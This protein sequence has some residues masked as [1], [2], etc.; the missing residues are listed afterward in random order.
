M[1]QQ[2]RGVAQLNEST[3]RLISNYG[4]GLYADRIRAVVREAIEEV[5]L[6]YKG[7]DKDTAIIAKGKTALR[8]LLTRW[9]K[10]E[11]AGSKLGKLQ[12]YKI[13]DAKLINGNEWLFYPEKNVNS[14]HVSW[15]VGQQE[16]HVKFDGQQPVTI[17]YN[18]AL[19]FARIGQHGG[20]PTPTQQ[21]QAKTIIGDWQDSMLIQYSQRQAIAEFLS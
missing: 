15:V 16:I 5:E 6:S 1:A 21:Q 9:Q 8:D 14:P 3:E 17:Y 19:Q 10:E 11:I 7:S 12:L 4:L 13:W 18:A 20:Q 2:S